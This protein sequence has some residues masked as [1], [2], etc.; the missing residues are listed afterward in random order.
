M[1]VD[2]EH[3]A[4]K[5]HSGESLESLNRRRPILFLHGFS[6]SGKDWMFLFD[7]LPPEYFPLSI[8][9][10]GHGE[11]DSPEDTELYTA[12]AMTGQIRELIDKLKLGKIVL[13]GYSM[14]GRLA[15]EFYF[16]FPDYLTGLV[17]ESSSPGIRKKPEREMRYE[18][19]KKL[20]QMITN[21]GIKLFVDHW[22]SL[23][24]FESL[25]RLDPDTYRLL[26]ETKLKN[27]VTGLAN[28]LLGFSQGRMDNHWD[29]LSNIKIPVLLIGG[30]EDQKYAAI[31]K[32]INNLTEGF[33]LSLIE[34]AGHNSHLEK[35]QDFIKL[36][37]KYLRT[38]DQLKC[39]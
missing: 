13:A 29:L 37:N 30:S 14:G 2:L 9:L 27:N 24:V 38:K 23:P 18:S 8:D 17:L 26:K 25:R 28:S 3:L 1:Y 4:L 6:G 34:G 10:I 20:A 22:L 11:S 16:R 5:L 33:T 12:Y 36:L 31:L 7:K 32:E 39:V 35:P 19:D 15:L 21:N